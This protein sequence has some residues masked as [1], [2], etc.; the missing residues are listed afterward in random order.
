MPQKGLDLFQSVLEPS[1]AKF[2]FTTPA[3]NIFTPKYNKL[4]PLVCILFYDPINSKLSRLYDRR[5]PSS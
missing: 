2:S 4:S 1:T 5:T 3:K